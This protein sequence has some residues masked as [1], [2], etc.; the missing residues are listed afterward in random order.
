M[1]SRFMLRL[2]RVVIL[3]SALGLLTLFAAPPTD[4][5]TGDL[6]DFVAPSSGNAGRGLTFDG[7][8]LWYAAK[9]DTNLYRLDVN[10][11]SVTTV[12]TRSSINFWALAI[13][14]RRLP[15]LSAVPPNPRSTTTATAP[16]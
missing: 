13:A 8:H 10:N 12:P 11:T 1:N 3:S 5:L 2:A 16:A 14:S 9:D 15:T 7:D 6:P 4:A